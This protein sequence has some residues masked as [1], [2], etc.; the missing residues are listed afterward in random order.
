MITVNLADFHAGGARRQNLIAAVIDVLR[1]D[2]WFYVIGHGVDDTLRERMFAASATFFAAP[3]ERKMQASFVR[4][5]DHRGFI[6]AYSFSCNEEGYLPDLCEAYK[7][8]CGPATAY[9]SQPAPDWMASNK[10][11]NHS[12]EMQL[13]LAQYWQQM[14]QV[15]DTLLRICALGLELPEMLFVDWCEDGVSNMSLLHYPPVSEQSK[16]RGIS[17]HTDSDMLTLLTPSP[18][19]GLYFQRPNGSWIDAGNDGRRLIVNTGEMM[20]LASG[21]RM[22]PCMH[23]VKNISGKNR[24][25]FPY[26]VAPAPDLTISPQLE[27]VDG[28]GAPTVH[29]GSVPEYAKILRLGREERLAGVA[30]MGLI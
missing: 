9:R 2:G 29:V 18:T 15:G 4:D 16:T 7:V 6:P 24:Y 11:F 10:W 30:K 12:T 8:Y 28:F 17:P 14:K 27:V 22:R 23:Y 19:G 20:E 5:K 13:V 3:V 1:L 25:S 21:G 26:F